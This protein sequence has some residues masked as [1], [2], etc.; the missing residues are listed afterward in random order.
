LK[1]N[2]FVCKAHT[3]IY[4]LLVEHG[5]SSLCEL[6]KTERNEY[7][8]TERQRMRDLVVCPLCGFSDVT[9]RFTLTQ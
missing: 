1:Q 9:S 2:G 4:D 3:A 8:R 5:F 7:N 6:T